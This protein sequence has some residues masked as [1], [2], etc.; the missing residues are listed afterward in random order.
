MKPSSTLVL[1]AALVCACGSKEVDASRCSNANVLEKRKLE[2][3]MTTAYA[4]PVIESC[5]ELDL[6]LDGQATSAGL[7]DGEYVSL[8]R[9]ANGNFFDDGTWWVKATPRGGS[10]AIPVQITDERCEAVTFDKFGYDYAFAT[11]PL[12]AAPACGRYMTGVNVGHKVGD[13][14]P[15]VFSIEGSGVIHLAPLSVSSAFGTFL[16][17]PRDPLDPPTRA[18]TIER[19]DVVRHD[20]DSLEVV[21]LTNGPSFSSALRLVLKVGEQSRLSVQLELEPRALAGGNPMIAV[22][23]LSGWFSND[24]ERDFDRVRAT[25]A[26]DTSF[27]TALSDDAVDWGKGEWTP[28]PVR[29]AGSTLES[30]A[31][32]QNG[33]GA[34]RGRPNVTLSNLQSSVPLAVDLSLSTQAVLGGNVVAN[35]LLDG[36]SMTSGPI[37]VSYLITVSPP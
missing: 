20:G 29:Q 31:F 5:P 11:P 23:A 34:G 16:R 10:R 19:I 2:A 6:P 36:S 37:S 12:I 28:L 13:S 15:Q 32:L 27:E 7:T 17:L 18:S 25:F 1:A 24:D 14:W 33:A 26:D 4:P 9:G 35:L 22:A 30:L 21:A 3:A 8:L